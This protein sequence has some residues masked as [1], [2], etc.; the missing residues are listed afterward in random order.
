[1]RQVTVGPKGA[2]AKI[3]E[4]GYGLMG[5]ISITQPSATHF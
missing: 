5:N 2:E 4:I 1:M 3:G